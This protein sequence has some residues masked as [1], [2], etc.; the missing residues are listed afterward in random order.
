[1]DQRSSSR[2]AVRLVVLVMAVAVAALVSACGGSD[3]EVEVAASDGGGATLDP[4]VLAG[5]AATVSGDVFDLGT[6]ADQDLVVWFWAP[7]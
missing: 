7:W 3:A 2:S 4:S 1:M 6:L 5:E